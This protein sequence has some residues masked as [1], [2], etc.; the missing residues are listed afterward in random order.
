MRTIQKTNIY[1]G[2]GKIPT[3]LLISGTVVNAA[4]SIEPVRRKVQEFV[5]G[6]TEGLNPPIQGIVRQAAI[7]TLQAAGAFSILLGATAREAKRVHEFIFDDAKAEELGLG[8]WYITLDKKR[9]AIVPINL[10]EQVSVKF[11]PARAAEAV[12]EVMK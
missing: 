2:S 7:P 9:Y 10:D 11:L 1:T 5:D 12:V 8:H 4:L 6:A 3:A